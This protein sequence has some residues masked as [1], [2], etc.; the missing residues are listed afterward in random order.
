MIAV[1][2]ISSDEL[3]GPPFHNR[4]E[5]EQYKTKNRAGCKEIKNP[6]DF[7]DTLLV[8]PAVERS[9]SYPA[10]VL[11]LEEK[12]FGLSILE[13]EDLA[14]STDVELALYIIHLSVHACP[15]SIRVLLLLLGRTFPG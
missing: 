13:A 7:R 4:K 15:Y 6:T 9:P 12:R 8:L 10:R 14:V 1:I 5:R 3:S 2:H 11:S